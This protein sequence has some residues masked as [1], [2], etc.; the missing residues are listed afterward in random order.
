M[1]ISSV[2][3]TQERKDAAVV[4]VPVWREKEA[5]LLAL[6]EGKEF[7]SLVQFSLSAGDFAGQ[8]GETLLLYRDAQ[9]LEKRVLLV[10]LGNKSSCTCAVLRNAYA[11]VVKAMRA[12]KLK[13]ANVL[14]PETDHIERES[15]CQ[16]AIEG[17]LMA[18][19]TFDQL[20]GESA[21]KK[22]EEA[23]LDTVCFCGLNKAE[24]KLLQK[25]EKVIDSVNFVRDL[26]NGNSD[27][28]TI[29]FLK[30]MA[31]DLGKKYS[32]SVKVKILDKR[33]LEEEKMGLMLAVG[34][35]AVHEPALVI[36]E[37]TGN[38]G[39]K[40]KI[41]IVGKGITYD[42]GGLN[43]KTSG[44]ETM[45]A[46]MAGAAVALGIVRAAAEL[47]L[48]VNF[49][50]ALALAEN[51]IG[52]SSYKPGDVYRSRSGKTVEISNTD[53]EGR[54]V[55][56][57]AVSYIEEKYGPKQLI[58]FATLT[59]GVVVAL[60]EEATGLFATDDA[61]AKA[62]EQSGERTQE[63]IW[64]L[65]LYAEYKEYLKSNIADIK[66]A[67]PRKASSG[68]GA[69]FIQAFIKSVP[70]AHLDIAGTAY[71][72]ELKPCHATPA[73]GVGIRLLVDFFEHCDGK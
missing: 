60:G 53:A 45:K 30:Q 17:I 11:S 46:D 32:S 38:P 21:Q 59:G 56:G 31:Q 19:Y 4:V 20:K 44:M 16:A 49:V 24:E 6:R 28:V 57:D 8:E 72:S 61:L 50:S 40:E 70:W 48:N 55:L 62:L 71:L 37:Y 52:P 35:A 43:I 73:T 41:A 2:S 7:A 3:N 69:T 54:L 51:A 65:P 5:P 1:H 67:G 22:G 68:S 26:V 33:A 14:L 63:R 29:S 13:S 58:D 25:T 39:S 15:L 42:T 36:L 64:R 12:K 18:R 23:R 34:K 10:G 9:G 47:Q 27:D 66:N